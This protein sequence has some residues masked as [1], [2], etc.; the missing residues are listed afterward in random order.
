MTG[1]ANAFLRRETAV[2]CPAM[3]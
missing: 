3:H 1:G 2:T